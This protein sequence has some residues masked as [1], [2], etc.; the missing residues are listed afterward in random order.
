ML[1]NIESQALSVTPCPLWFLE[2]QFTTEDAEE[3]RVEDR[4]DVWV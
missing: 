2:C 1:T 3:H 4:G